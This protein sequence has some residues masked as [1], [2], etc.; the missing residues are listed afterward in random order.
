MT[1]QCPHCNS[2]IPAEEGQQVRFCPFCGKS[3]V[4]AQAPSALA[5]QLQKEKKP[6]KKYE[7]IQAALA[8]NPDDF[9]ANR[10]LLFH[11][12]LHEPLMMKG[13]RTDYSIIKCHLMNIF[14]TPENYSASE[15]ADKY[16][17]L[18]RS[19]QL[20]KTMSLAPDPDAFFAEYLY[21]L[22]FQYI[23]LFLRGD[24]KYN[25]LAFGI[26]RSHGAVA[27]QCA[28]PVRRMLATAA[29]SAFLTPEEKVLLLGAL[30]EGYNR[31]FSGYAENLDE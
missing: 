21:D 11:G 7:L 2:N 31:V 14:D 5:Q 13:Q 15:L 27:R 17:E 30:R 23:D 20:S 18:L 3:L 4:P 8:A 29:A 25:A 9:D 24:S 26:A 22:A 1:T 28:V 16:E 12:R 10:A 19:A 6:K